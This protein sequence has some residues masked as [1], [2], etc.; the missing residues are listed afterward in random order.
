MCAKTEGQSGSNGV[1][2]YV[3]FQLERNG[4]AMEKKLSSSRLLQLASVIEPASHLEGPVVMLFRLCCVFLSLQ[5]PT[6]IMWAAFLN[7]TAQ[8]LAL[9]NPFQACGV[10][11]RIITN[12]HF[13]VCVHYMLVEHVLP[14]ISKECPDM[15]LRETAPTKTGP[16]LLP[17]EILVDFGCSRTHDC[18]PRESI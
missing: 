2:I 7:M 11:S 17:E 9:L 6:L 18:Y 14:L 5:F 10:Y 1:F 3:T 13:T 4:K 16:V 15:F 8:P 12:Q